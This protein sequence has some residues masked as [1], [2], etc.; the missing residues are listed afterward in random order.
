MKILIIGYGFV[1][2]ALKYVLESNPV[3]QIDVVDPAYSDFKVEQSETPSFTFICVPTPSNVDGSCDYS[4]V[5]QVLKEVKQYH[6]TTYVVVKSTV[7]PDGIDRLLQVDSDLTYNPEFLTAANALDDMLN[8]KFQLIGNDGEPGQ[9]LSLLYWGTDMVKPIPH[10][11]MGPKEAAFAK[12]AINSFLAL[13]VAYFNELYSVVQSSGLDWKQISAGIRQDPR[14]SLSH[15]QVPGPDGLFG[16]GGAC[17]PKDTQAFVR[18]A[19][20]VDGMPILATAIAE[21]KKRRP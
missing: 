8:S 15:T 1:G 17:F 10:L 2:K 14:I 20:L 4:M 11:Y 12:Y 3:N 7:T 13:K 9:M 5:E 16:F 6:P 18:F 19:E 21:N